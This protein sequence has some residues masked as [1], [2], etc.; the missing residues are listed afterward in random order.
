[1]HIALDRR[2]DYAIRALIALARAAHGERRKI[3]QIA[4]TMDIP[5]G[6]LPQVMT[7]LVRHGL[8]RATAGRDGGYELARPAG[9]VTL[10]EVIELT[11]GPLT[12]EHCLLVGGP[13]DW[14]QACPLHP[15]WARAHDALWRRT[16]GD[17]LRRTR[18]E[19]P[20]DRGR[21]VRPDRHRSAPAPR[22]AARTA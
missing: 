8:V 17:D 1:M 5:E 18:G 3:R 7:P 15:L 11:Q 21:H 4:K 13:C 12:E 14:E 6:Y 2:S 19:R 22:G 9:T 20:P 16:A 10:L